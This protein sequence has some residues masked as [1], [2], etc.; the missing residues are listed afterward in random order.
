MRVLIVNPQQTVSHIVTHTCPWCRVRVR[1]ETLGADMNISHSNPDASSGQRFCPSCRGLLFV[2]FEQGQLMRAYPHLRIDFDATDVPGK[3]VKTFS[4]ALD[5]HSHRYFIAAA[6]LVR[7]T[8][9]EVCKDRGATG[10]DLKARIQELKTKVILPPELFDA[11]DELRVLG[12]D[13]AHV[14][15]KSY[16]EIGTEEL[17]AAIGFTKE[18]LKGVYQFKGLLAKLQALKKT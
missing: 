4:E 1:F 7:R 18:V 16:D 8:L 15:A 12:N 10:K 13:A 3:I 14:E 17:E 2:Y 6:I 9:E 11:M 5:C